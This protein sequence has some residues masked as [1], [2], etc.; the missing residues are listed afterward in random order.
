MKV[1]INIDL[2]CLSLTSFFLFLWNFYQQSF[3]YKS[4]NNVIT[5]PDGLSSQMVFFLNRNF[6]Q[7]EQ[8]LPSMKM[9]FK[10][11]FHSQE[12]DLHFTSSNLLVAL[13]PLYF[14]FMWNGVNVNWYCGKALF[15]LATK[16]PAI[17]GPIKAPTQHSS[18][19]LS[20]P[21]ETLF[22]RRYRS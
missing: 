1:T 20:Q 22:D 4:Q 9:F 19:D 16:T 2:I 13:H 10:T 18:P 5:N 6:E 15:A 14:L 3:Q 17:F 11:M 12:K 8:I 7:K 21:R